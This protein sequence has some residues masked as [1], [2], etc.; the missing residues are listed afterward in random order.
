MA[1][2]GVRP[3]RWIEDVAA[4]R[5]RLHETFRVT[6]RN[7]MLGIVFGIMVP[8]GIYCMVKT[9]QYRQDELMGRGKREYF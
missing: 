8:V 2:G 7:A 5:E 1:G 6:P 3:N 9:N 4:R